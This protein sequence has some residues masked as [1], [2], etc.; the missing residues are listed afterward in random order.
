MLIT[1]YQHKKINAKKPKTANRRPISKCPKTHGKAPGLRQ[2]GFSADLFVL[3]KTPLPE[4]RYSCF[5][6]LLIKIFF[7]RGKQPHY[8]SVAS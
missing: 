7:M 2:N 4:A 3:H 8:K 1:L 6:V 5:S